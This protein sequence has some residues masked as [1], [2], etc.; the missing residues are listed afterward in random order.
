MFRI[1]IDIGNQFG[2]RQF[3]VDFRFLAGIIDGITNSEFHSL[4]K[5]GN[6]SGKKNSFFFSSI[7]LGHTLI[8]SSVAKLCVMIFSLNDVIG[9]RV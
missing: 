1:R 5:N 4:R 2:D 9:S 7:Q 6:V 8:S 3:F